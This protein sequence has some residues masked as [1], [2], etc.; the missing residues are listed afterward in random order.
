MRGDSAVCRNA[1]R[2]GCAPRIFIFYGLSE[3]SSAQAA[4][5]RREE[6][7]DTGADTPD[8]RK[9]SASRSPA[10]DS[11]AKSARPG[12]DTLPSFSTQ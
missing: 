3:A 2:T 11:F 10:D 6:P 12:M 1:N 7:A 5:L 8:T 9:G 4:W